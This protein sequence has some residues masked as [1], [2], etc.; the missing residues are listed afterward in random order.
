MFYLITIISNKLLKI[1]FIEFPIRKISTA[2]LYSIPYFTTTT[3]P[4]EIWKR[5]IQKIPLQNLD[6]FYTW[7][8]KIYL[9]ICKQGEA[10][11]N[12]KKLKLINLGEVNWVHGVM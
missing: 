11:L 10:R 4:D 1:I 12:S 8:Y 6:I 3:L 2:S 5:E 9:E 7:T